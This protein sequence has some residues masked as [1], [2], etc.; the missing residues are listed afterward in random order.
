MFGTGI[1]DDVPS[2]CEIFGLLRH[3]FVCR[4]G[5]RQGVAPDA[6]RDVVGGVWAEETTTAPTC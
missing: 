6:L 2:F 5:A 3:R 4:G 1:G